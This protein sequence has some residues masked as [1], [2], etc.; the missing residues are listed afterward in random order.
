MKAYDG[1][2]SEQ[3]IIRIDKEH[4]KKLLSCFF[5]ICY[6]SKD[7]ES[8]VRKGAIR[9]A[10]WIKRQNGLLLVGEAF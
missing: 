5:Y 6:N 1:T 7:C 10:C 4:D 3:C 8:F 9:I 2:G